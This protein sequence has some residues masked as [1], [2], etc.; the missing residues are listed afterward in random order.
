MRDEPEALLR[1]CAP[2][3]DGDGVA[4]PGTSHF[5]LVQVLYRELSPSLPLPLSGSQM[6]ISSLLYTPRELAAV[7][8]TV[9]IRFHVTSS[10]IDACGSERVQVY[11]V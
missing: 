5:C 8:S 6:I 3:L 10:D 2:A 9:H 11:R 7:P 1:A 4:S